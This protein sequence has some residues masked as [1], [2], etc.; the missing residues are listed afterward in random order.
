MSLI[1]DNPPEVG[2]EEK[3]VLEEVAKTVIEGIMS[4]EEN[5]VM[6]DFWPG[7]ILLD[8]ESDEI[9]RIFVIDWE[10]AKPGLQGLDVGQFCAEVDLLRRFY[11]ENKAV[12]SRIISSFYRSYSS[13]DK[14]N[15]AD[16]L[17]RTAVTHWGAHLVVW[18]PRV[19]WGGQ[20]ETR[21]VVKAGV[22][23]IV[24]VDRDDGSFVQ[25]IFEEY[26]M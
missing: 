19:S 13:L 2:E 9:R 22:D 21:K 6:G 20:D 4:A 8:S 23:Q 17:Y 1:C 24:N 10:L 7:N 15:G 26:K 14:S 5:F 12:S 18:T 11:P 16:S 3:K 25:K